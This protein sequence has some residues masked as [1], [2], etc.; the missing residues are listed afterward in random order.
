MSHIAIQSQFYL[1]LYQTGNTVPFQLCT[2]F[3]RVFPAPCWAWC[4]ESHAEGWWP[5][6]NKLLGRTGWVLCW[7]ATVSR[8]AATTDRCWNYRKYVKTKI[9]LSL[10]LNRMDTWRQTDESNQTAECGMSV[11]R[12]LMDEVVQVWWYLCSKKCFLALWS[13]TPATE[14]LYQLFFNGLARIWNPWTCAAGDSLRAELMRSC[15][16]IETLMTFNIF[17]VKAIQFLEK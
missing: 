2:I 1:F 10:R 12:A 17:L 7:F 4:E 14:V 6:K 15:H 11:Y 8:G 3:H 16:Y 13:T 9:S 5:S